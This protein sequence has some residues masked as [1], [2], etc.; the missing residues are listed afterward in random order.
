MESP[1]MS[2]VRWCPSIWGISIS[3]TTQQTWLVMGSLSALAS[4]RKSQA[5][6][7]LSVTI[8]FSYPAFR[9]DSVII[10]ERSMESSARRMG[11]SLRCRGPILSMSST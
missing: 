1:L 8:R 3:V 11:F 4:T 2:F 10:R 6:W 5:S 7:P 9:R